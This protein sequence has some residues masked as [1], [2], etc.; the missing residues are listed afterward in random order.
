MILFPRLFSRAI[1]QLTIDPDITV[2]CGENS[3]YIYDGIPD[4]AS[5]TGIH[6][7]SD[8]LGVFCTQDIKYPV[9]VEAKSGL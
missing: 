5:T 3:V 7:R 8:T 2:S 4:F 1:I 9:I 6:Q